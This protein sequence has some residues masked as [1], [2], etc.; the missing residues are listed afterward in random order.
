MQRA[1]A[2]NLSFERHPSSKRPSNDV[3][4]ITFRQ[5]ICNTNGS[6]VFGGSSSPSSSY[7]LD[8][9]SCVMFR[10]QC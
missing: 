1:R 7:Q 4:I 6:A 3:G 8:A 2:R 9:T 10:I 5:K